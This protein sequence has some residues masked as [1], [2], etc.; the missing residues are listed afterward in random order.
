MVERKLDFVGNSVYSLVSIVTT[1]T[2][3]VMYEEGIVQANDYGYLDV[4]CNPWFI[5]PT[6]KFQFVNIVKIRS[7]FLEKWL[8]PKVTISQAL[9]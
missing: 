5:H 6:I 4:C 2:R 7:Y 1:S 3:F 9:H 8:N